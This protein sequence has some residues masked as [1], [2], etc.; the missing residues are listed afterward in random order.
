MRIAAAG[1]TVD[2]VARIPRSDLPSPAIY[3]VTSRGVARCDIYL[4]DRDHRDFIGLL[5][6]VAR[7]WNWRCPAYTLMSNHFHLLVDARIE[8]VSRGM[9]TLKGAYARQ[10]NE[11][12]DRVGH[13]FQGRFEIR[14]LAGE[15]HLRNA[16]EYI[17]NN[18]VRVGMCETAADW[19]WNGS[20]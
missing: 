13:L 9:Q 6:V 4:D 14:V 7:R 19:P 1:A 12:H 8:D 17:W 15:E 2:R 11:D 18:P 5:R 10:F 16:C 20:V 3:H